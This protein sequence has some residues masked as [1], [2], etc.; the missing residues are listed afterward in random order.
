MDQTLGERLRRVH[1]NE[2]G[3][4]LRLVARDEG[5]HVDGKS[6]DACFADRRGALLPVDNPSGLLGVWLVGEYGITR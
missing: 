3:S 5:G 1:E 6:L 4:L 2:L